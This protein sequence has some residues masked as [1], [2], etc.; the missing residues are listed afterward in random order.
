MS[1]SRRLEEKTKLETGV[2]LAG[3]GPS[4]CGLGLVL[5]IDTLVGLN[6]SF[7][8]LSWTRLVWRFLKLYSGSPKS[9]G[10]LGDLRI[11]VGLHAPSY[12]PCHPISLMPL[13]LVPAGDQD[14][15]MLCTLKAWGCRPKTSSLFLLKSSHSRLGSPRNVWAGIL[16]IS[17][18]VHTQGSH[19]PGPSVSLPSATP[20][21]LHTGQRPQ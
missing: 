9:A 18:S 13:A 7:L 11:C 4:G 12:G 16:A 19:F 2:P 5:P 20:C 21:L 10:P 14:E 1:D 15:G 3:A 6:H 17:F 8:V